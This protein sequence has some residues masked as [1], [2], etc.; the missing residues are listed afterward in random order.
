[1]KLNTVFSYVT[2]TYE[3]GVSKRKKRKVY[4]GNSDK[5]SS[6]DKDDNRDSDEDDNN[7]SDDDLAAR[8][9]RGGDLPD[10]LDLGD[11]SQ[12]S[13]DDL[14]EDNEDDREWNALGAALER[15]FLSE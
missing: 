3:L 10:D 13:V 7:D 15:E 12:D 4:N 11:N 9:R 1:M 14:E 6:K 5:G 2:D 8:F